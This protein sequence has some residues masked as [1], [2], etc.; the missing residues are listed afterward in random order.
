M[1]VMPEI[2]I[3][4]FDFGRKRIGIAVGTTVLHQARA[5]TT[6][7]SDKHSVREQAIAL[8]VNEWQPDE[9]VVGLP[10]HMDGREHATTQKARAFAE[11]LHERFQLP[12]HLV[13]ERLTTQI[14]QTMLEEDG[15]YGDQAKSVRDAVAAQVILQAY[16]DERNENIQEA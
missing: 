16:L 14:A 15:V 6:I 9:L 11:W 3:L 2:T 12:V 10:V 1:P 13:D 4:A 8:L 5:L 7:A